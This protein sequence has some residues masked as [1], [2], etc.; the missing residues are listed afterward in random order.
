M[1]LQMYRCS[2]IFF[3]GSDTELILN[4][5]IFKRQKEKTKTDAESEYFP[6]FPGF[7]TTGLR[8]D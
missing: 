5:C 8:F 4:Y 2:M 6:L 7:T 1:L 3:P